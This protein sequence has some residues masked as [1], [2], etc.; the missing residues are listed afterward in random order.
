[1]KKVIDFDED[2][3]DMIQEFA[4]ENCRRNFTF[5]VDTLCRDGLL[6]HQMRKFK[7]RDKAEG[8]DK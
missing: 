7:A 4:N 6:A 5:A 1:M 2:L 3:R 8:G